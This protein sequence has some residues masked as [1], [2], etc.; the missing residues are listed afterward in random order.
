MPQQKS[1]LH[2]EQA[3]VLFF[4]LTMGWTFLWVSNAIRGHMAGGSNFHAIAQSNLGIEL[5]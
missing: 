3:F 2:T 4:R 1:V 5:E